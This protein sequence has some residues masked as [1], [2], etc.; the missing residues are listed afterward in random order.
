MR[1]GPLP[2][3]EMEL[4]LPGDRIHKTEDIAGLDLVISLYRHVLQLAV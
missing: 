4:C 3:L 2:E 1:F